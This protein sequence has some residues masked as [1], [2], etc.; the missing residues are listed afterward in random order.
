L[1]DGL[2]SL[3]FTNGAY[4]KTKDGEMFFGGINGFNSFYPDSFKSHGFF[5]K[6]GITS[7]KILNKEIPLESNVI[8][9]GYSENSISI[10]FSSFDF[11]DPLKN[12]YAYKLDGHE[13]VWHN[14][15]GTNR[16]AV[17]NN[18]PPGKYTFRLTGSGFLGDSFIPNELKIMIDSP[19]YQ[20]WW[21]ILIVIFIVG[22]IICYIVWTRINQYL[23]VQKLKEKLSADLHDSIGSGLT[24]ISLLSAVARNYPETDA[25]MQKAKLKAIGDRA[26]ELIDNMSDIVW[27]VNPKNKSL[28]DLILRLKDSYSALCNS[29][30]ISFKLINIEQLDESGIIMEKRQN[31]YLIFKEG[32]NNSIKYSGCRNI[33]LSVESDNRKF[34]ITLRDDGSGFDMKNKT[35]GNGLNNMK[36]RAQESGMQLELESSEVYGTV[37]CLKGKLK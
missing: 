1:N 4:Y 14:T 33:T 27:L 34:I 28:K 18:L 21:F 3:R 17:Y 8:S 5:Q 13:N 10:E 23:S 26:G 16:T 11:A 6:P 37:I 29:I 12:Q 7:F 30:G 22:G 15:T 32:I 24:E 20:K 9:L 31:I 25:G 36:K 19:F 2:Q 35:S